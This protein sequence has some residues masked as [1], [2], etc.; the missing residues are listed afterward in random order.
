MISSDSSVLASNHSISRVT[1][2]KWRR[3]SFSVEKFIASPISRSQIFW[4]NSSLEAEIFFFL[5]PSISKRTTSTNSR[6]VAFFV[7]TTAFISIKSK[8]FT[9]EKTYLYSGISFAK[10]G[11]FEGLEEVG[12]VNNQ[13]IIFLLTDNKLQHSVKLF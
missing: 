1:D 8:N 2:S 13:A 12:Y 5:P 7:K 6:I 9:Y 11:I 10:V 3:S 4:T